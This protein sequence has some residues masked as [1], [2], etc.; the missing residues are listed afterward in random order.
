MM[1]LMQN[2]IN[3]PFVRLESLEVAV[4]KNAVYKHDLKSFSAMP[5]SLFLHDALNFH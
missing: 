3:S 1:W 5:R 2:I 4:L